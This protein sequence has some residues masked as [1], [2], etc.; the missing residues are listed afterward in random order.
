M[1][2]PRASFAVEGCRMNGPGQG[3]KTKSIVGLR[4]NRL[5][6]VGQKVING[7]TMAE[8]DCDCG[9]SCVVRVSRL[10]AGQE[11]CG[12]QRGLHSCPG[13]KKVR[14]GHSAEGHA[15]PTYSSW[16][17]M[18]GRCTNPNEPSWGS[19]GGRGITV[20][21]RW[22]LFDNFLA[23]MGKR[24]SVDVSL[25]RIDNSGNYEPGNCR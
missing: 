1:P 9:G 6:V 16:K 13:N 3:I 25:D 5:V 15:T 24:P 17:S 21:E 7:R 2:R 23:D 18:M 11:G 19:Y 22:G 10:Y 8:C 4:F 14:H 20:C 12:C